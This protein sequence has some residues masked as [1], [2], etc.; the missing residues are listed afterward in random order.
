MHLIKP[1]WLTHGGEKKDFEVY[2]CHVSPDG[3]R[4]VTAAGDGYVRIWSTEAIYQAAN[5][6]F[7]KP[8]QLASMSYHSGTIHTV[9]FSPGGKFVASGAD[10]KI[11]CVY[12]LDPNPASHS[13]TFGSNEPPPV[14]NWRIFRRL[15]GHDNDVQDLGWSC[16][17]SILVSV[18]LDSKIVVWSGHTFEKLKTLSNHQSHVKGITFDPANKYFATASDDRTIKVF[19]FT[20]PGPNSSAHDQ[21]NNFTLEH[22]V[23][24][25]F[26]NSPLTTYFRRCSW[27]PDG[28]HIAAANAVNGPVSAIAIINRGTWDGDNTLIGHEGP[29]EVCAF[30][31]R[32]YGTEPFPRPTAEGHAPPHITV[33]ACAGGDKSLSVWTT[34][35]P[36]P[37]FVSQDAAAKPLSDLAW[38]PD[39]TSLF[40]TAL[41][42]TILALIFEEGELGY[43]WSV[44]ENDRSLAKF[45]TGRKGVG[46]IETVEGLLLE[47]R[48]KAG[49]I[50]GVEGRMGALMG[51]V[52]SSQ[53]TANS[54]V[55]TNGNT[56]TIATLN[57]TTPAQVDTPG[58]D[59]QGDKPDPNQ[60]KLERL[61]SR[62]EITKDGKKRIK[63]LLVSSA[64]GAESSLP[65][66]RLISA[67]ATAQT[68]DA[69]Q[70][71]LDL[72][73]P[74]D[75]LPKGGL[76]SLLL[77]NKRKFAQLEDDDDGHIEKRITLA[78]QNG[79][80]PIVTNGPD[81]LLPAQAL[82][83][84]N[85]Q[86]TTP[87]FIRP[88]VMNPVLTVSQLRLAVPKVRTH[89]LQGVDQ[90]GDPVDVSGVSQDS[91][92]KSRADL[93]FEARNPAPQSLT[94]RAQDREPCRITLTR[95]DQPLWQDFLPRTVLLVTGNKD[96]WAAADEAGSVYIWTPAGR[97][98]VNALVLEAQPVILAAKYQWLLCI[99]AVGMCYV[100]DVKNMTSPH[101]PISLAPV[102]DAA[103]HTMTNHPTASPAITNARVN[104]EGRIVVSLSNG[105]GYAY[106]PHMY[107]WQRLSEVWWAVGSQYWNTTDSSVG[108]IQ[109]AK[110]NGKEDAETISAGI[111]PFLERNTTNETLLRGRAYFLQ[112]LIKVL[113]SRE[114]FESF[115]AG[116]SIAHLEN[117]VAAALM[118]GAKEEFRLYLLMYAKRL[119]AEGL[120]LKVEELLRLLLGGIVD[121]GDKKENGAAANGEGR[122]WQGE[123]EKICGWPRNELLKDVI[124]LL[125][126]LC[127][128]FP[129]SSALLTFVQASTETY[130]GSPYHMHNFSASWETKPRML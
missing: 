119:G 129:C 12:N 116:I 100:W 54:T 56:P 67:A 110:K 91:S 57:G 84:I 48:S 34:N 31:P 20:S 63:P 111:I 44:E 14:E 71:I 6:S 123:S 53:P 125:G 3:A 59:A 24:A 18:G 75:G 96:F 127:C 32:L 74:F 17:G 115:E 106:S 97:R 66:S 124:L 60:A 69:P 104:S 51:D 21:M 11:V 88:A 114:G 117:R 39:G 78:S 90:G 73:K 103:I 101:P 130:K 52:P 61:K 16:D 4:L 109:T 30:S 5:P 35:N 83:A 41:D 102:L 2:S 98:L 92:T 42:G 108:N 112:R 8:R 13:S 50:K 49:E 93:V 107:T 86:Q 118:L 81:G 77:G 122:N 95:K 9:R 22:T 47:E 33:I 80:T 105:D 65:Q 64:G 76:A 85:G 87:E 126:K 15:I 46:V 37:A 10:D 40:A 82:P 121:E 45:G 26:A 28:M 94:G 70:S 89:I 99:T 58:G 68:A 38:S 79:A 29:V 72:S 55:L 62:V 7:S 1:T 120:R 19:Q 23:T 113:L 43:P 36:R 27:S 128:S 25:P